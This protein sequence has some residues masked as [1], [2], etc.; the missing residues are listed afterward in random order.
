MDLLINSLFD[1]LLSDESETYRILWLNPSMTQMA[2]IRLWVERLETSVIQVSDFRQAVDNHQIRLLKHDPFAL[3]SRPDDMF[4]E[5][6]RQQRDAA[7]E[8]IKPL[9]VDS[10]P[11]I[12]DPHQRGSLIQEVARNTHKSKQTLYTQVRIYFQRGQTPNTLAPDF[13]NRGGPGKRKTA[14]E[15]KRGRPNKNGETTGVNITDEI[16]QY[17]DFGKQLLEKREVKTQL[18]AFD[19]VNQ[20]FFKLGYEIKEGQPVAILPPEHE[21]PKISQ[22]RTYLRE[23]L[24]IVKMTEATIGEKRFQSNCR[25]MHGDSTTM[26]F[27]TGSLAQF[28]STPV[29]VYL[30]SQIDP[31]RIIS[32]VTLYLGVDVFSHM[33]AAV[34]ISLRKASWEG[35][36]VAFS[37]AATDK[38][39][40]CKQHGINITPNQ[41]PC[42]NLFD[43]LLTDRGE[44]NNLQN[45]SI[46]TALDVN[47]SNASPYRADMKG[48]IEQL[49]NIMNEILIDEL[50]GSIPDE[51]VRGDSDYRL[52]ARL[53]IKAFRRLVLRAILYYNQYQ[54]IRNYPVDLF[55]ISDGVPKIPIKLWNWGIANRGGLLRRIDNQALILNLLPRS[56][57]SLTRDGIYFKGIYYECDIP[58]IQSRID[59]IAITKKR[60]SLSISHHPF[61]KIDEIYLHLGKGE[62]ALCKRTNN[63][64]TQVFPG[65]SFEEVDN[66]NIS[67]TERI[68]AQIGQQHQGRAEL[69]AHRDSEVETS[70]KIAEQAI[71]DSGLSPHARLKNIRENTKAEQEFEA[72]QLQSSSDA[73]IDAQNN[74]AELIAE[75]A[76]QESSDVRGQSSSN[77]KSFVPRPTYSQLLRQLA[78]EED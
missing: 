7:Y 47:F 11:Q 58:E 44:G 40:L 13:Q 69:H 77:Q 70:T 25:S 29:D 62:T 52:N 66:Y 72:Q 59:R 73:V 71:R 46:T 18:A 50:P 78:E 6:A 68:N 12:F 23:E 45:R 55:M 53:D 37:S 34:E 17:F 5:A 22:F 10:I 63:P 26:A 9:V 65:F 8:L 39:L 60:E 75:N 76:N 57:A 2:I 4:S 15:K 20:N 67:E 61:D 31:S 41:W 35:F 19:A 16:R 1:W 51:V 42:N 49:M 14:G 32:R 21:R 56:K 28:D 36:K 24:D 43:E 27:S 3:Y 48:I 33:I 74:E 64:K 30:T 54:Y 38:V